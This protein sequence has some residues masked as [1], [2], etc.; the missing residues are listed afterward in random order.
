MGRYLYI[1]LYSS[2]SARGGERGR[3]SV[4]GNSHTI[5]YEY[6]PLSSSVIFFLPRP[7]AQYYTVH[8]SCTMYTYK[9]INYMLYVPIIFIYIYI[10]VCVYIIREEFHAVRNERERKKIINILTTDRSM[11]MAI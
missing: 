3:G 11:R 2:N 6:Y 1:I 8:I 7:Q 4:Y 10:Y 9:Y 5:K